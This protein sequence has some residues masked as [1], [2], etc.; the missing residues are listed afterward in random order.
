MIG[1]RGFDRNVENGGRIGR[2]GRIFCVGRERIRRNPLEKALRGEGWGT[3]KKERRWK[4][5]VGFAISTRTL[6]GI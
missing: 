6:G 3:R 1:R 4:D 2:I 5:S